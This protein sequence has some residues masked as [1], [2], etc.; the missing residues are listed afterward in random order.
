MPFPRSNAARLGL[1][2]PQHRMCHRGQ[3]RQWSPVPLYP[4][5]VLP[6]CDLRRSH[7]SR[8]SPDS[9]NNPDIGCF[10]LC[11]SLQSLFPFS[12]CCFAAQALAPPKTS[13]L[14]AW[15]KKKKKR[16]FTTQ[17]HSTPWRRCGFTSF[18]SPQ[19]FE[20]RGSS[21]IALCNLPRSRLS[22]VATRLSLW[23]DLVGAFIWWYGAAAD[24]GGCI[25]QG[26]KR[27]SPNSSS[28]IES[29]RKLSGG[30]HESFTADT[31]V[32][33]HG[34]RKVK[35]LE[36]CYAAT[37]VGWLAGKQAGCETLGPKISG[38]GA[39]SL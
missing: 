8:Y 23:R 21:C 29:E 26:L 25:E 31:P 38:N 13:L 7:A 37:L 6:E 36:R 15:P 5:R 14:G 2:R 12:P 18:S 24:P 39:D 10:S 11:S 32:R 19:S 3:S 20:A 9:T 1:S 30:P 22:P 16:L 27:G 28:S 4:C 34:P 17:L 33:P 35:K